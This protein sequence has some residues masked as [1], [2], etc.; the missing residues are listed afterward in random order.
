MADMELFVL[1]EPQS[2]WTDA[3]KAGLFNCAEAGGWLRQLPAGAL[4][5]EDGFD[6]GV[7]RMV[8]VEWAATRGRNRLWMERLLRAAIGGEG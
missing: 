1:V 5:I 4:L 3:V 8:E 2:S 6:A 7:E